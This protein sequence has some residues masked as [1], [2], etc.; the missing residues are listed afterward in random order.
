M[1]SSAHRS[2]WLLKRRRPLRRCQHVCESEIPTAR[3]TSCQWVVLLV[4]SCISTHVMLDRFICSEVHRMCWTCSHPMSAPSPAV[5]R[6]GH[7]KPA[8]STTLDTPLHNVRGPSTLDMV[9]MALLMPVY[10]AVG[11]GLTICIRVCRPTHQQPNLT[12]PDQANIP[13]SS[14]SDT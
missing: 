1:D 6:Q 5:F 2:L 10:T 9:T 13:S 3:H 4:C 12:Q 14:L 8:P 11:D 7:R